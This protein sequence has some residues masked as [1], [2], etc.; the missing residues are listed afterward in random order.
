MRSGEGEGDR[1]L[2]EGFLW[3]CVGFG[4]RRGGEFRSLCTS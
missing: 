1:V 3:V 4:G 2:W